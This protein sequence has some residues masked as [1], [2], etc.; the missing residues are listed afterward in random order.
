M[1]TEAL[2]VP[3][4]VFMAIH[5]P[6]R[7]YKQSLTGEEKKTG[8]SQEQLLADFMDARDGFRFVPVLGASG[9][10][11]SHLIRWLKARIDQTADRRVI[12]IP[13]TGTNLREVIRLIL[14]G[15][16]G[17]SFDNYR[18]Q[19]GEASDPVTVEE[20]QAHL[21]GNI[22]RTIEYRAD[23]L[24]QS[25]HERWD[26]Q[27]QMAAAEVCEGLPY[28]LNDPHFRGQWL[29][30]EGVIERIYD[31]TLGASQTRERREE[32][33][34]F[35][36]E[37]LPLDVT[38]LASA[39]KLSR[40]FFTQL[41]SHDL[42]QEV[43]VEVLNA[44]LE[45]A[46]PQV[47]GMSGERLME[48]ML[49]VRKSLAA[50]EVELVLLIEDF[51]KLQG[52]DR[53]L[54]EALLVRPNQG[55]ESLCAMRTA[56]ACTTGYYRNFAE[57]VRTRASF[58]VDLNHEEG[59]EVD[60]Q[61]FVARYLNAVRLGEDAIQEWYKSGAE[62]EALPSGC[63]GCPHRELCHDGFGEQMNWGLYPFNAAAVDAMYERTE[64]E[65]F[66]PRYLIK[67][68]LRHTLEQHTEEIR[69]GRFPSVALH[70]HFKGLDPSLAANQTKLQKKDP[71]NVDR[72]LALLD[73]WTSGSAVVN[74]HPAIHTAFDLPALEDV[75]EEPEPRKEPATTTVEEPPKQPTSD[76]VDERLQ[77][78]MDA[79]DAWS[80]GEVMDQNLAQTLRRQLYDVLTNRIDWDDEGLLQTSF[81]ARTGSAPFRRR[82]INF[83][84]QITNILDSH[85]R[86]TLP[87]DGESIFEVAQALKGM[88]QFQDHGNWRFEEGTDYYVAYARYVEK[89]AQEIV[90]Q[91]RHPGDVTEP[92]SPVE[93]VAE[94]LSTGTRMAGQPI[95]SHTAIDHRVNAL[96]YDMATAQP[97]EV[98]SAPWKRLF[99]RFQKY[100][101][102]DSG[103]NN[104]GLLDLLDAYALCAKGGSRQTKFYDVAQFM[105]VLE[106]RGRHA[107]QIKTTIP[108]DLPSFF[109]SLT[110]VRDAYND[111]QED[112]IA[113]ERAYAVE[114]IDDMRELLGPDLDGS[115]AKD[116]VR[117]VLKLLN[118]TGSMPSGWGEGRIGDLE[119]RL[120]SFARS[121]F[122]YAVST[123]ERIEE[124]DGIDAH[125][126]GRLLGELGWMDYKATEAARDALTYANGFLTDAK[127]TLEIDVRQLRRDGGA[128]LEAIHA[129][130]RASLSAT[131]R[132]LAVIEPSREL[133]NE[134][135]Q[136]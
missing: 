94:V 29:R 41:L 108:A 33:R 111:L 40:D 72:R 64:A 77:R 98:S 130:I 136:R 128:D 116:A 125:S 69:E 5:H 30:E 80:T 15:M 135:I 47:V 54:L 53:Q 107:W 24:R 96:F 45:I 95:R 89:W 21:L 14:K 50:Q 22:A 134:S 26:R 32:L 6:M 76:P 7:M 133:S 1:D 122:A 71:E 93:A 70:E 25:C 56:L 55:G 131:E 91:I 119:S 100:Q 83:K 27:Q 28:L 59:Q 39:S 92:W 51:A 105:D 68:V 16:E 123:A 38:D 110:N 57:T 127:K 84:N 86:L 126:M 46:I 11:K 65:G 60:K 3:D 124:E 121:N 43:A 113:K 36:V 112:A 48:L 12:L 35:S 49:D 61:E 17:E 82:D 10:G 44:S 8:Y 73:L 19:L 52:I 118:E 114:W 58:R 4:H 13:K 99:S 79:L 97:A 63:E 88:L 62:T 23:D 74:L 106:S 2:Q 20:G 67:D 129:E 34:Q 75:A 18:A 31:I 103:K 9:T 104:P 37:D 85:V 102:P 132:N 81:C 87:L 90:R 42:M 101:A 117:D 115:A 66:N 78:Q 109:D 120:L